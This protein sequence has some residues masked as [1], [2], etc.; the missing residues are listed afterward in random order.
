MTFINVIQSNLN[1]FV[2]RGCSVLSGDG[3]LNCK[4]LNHYWTYGARALLS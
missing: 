2:K 3:S 4:G 1:R